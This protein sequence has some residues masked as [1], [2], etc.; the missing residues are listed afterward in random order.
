M[1]LNSVVWTFQDEGFH[2]GRRALFVRL[3]SYEKEYKTWS[4][5]NDE[6]FIEMISRETSKLAVITG[7]EPFECL[8]LERIISILKSSGFQ[9]SIETK[10]SEKIE[11]YYDWITC[12]PTKENDYKIDENLK[13]YINEYNYV[14]DQNFDLFLLDR[15]NDDDYKVSLY[16]S[17]DYNDFQKSFNIISNYIKDHKRWRFSL[18]V[19]KY[20]NSFNGKYST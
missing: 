4:A 7:G 1:L 20:I 18:S 11:N 17:P 9:I 15:H 12:S 13:K 10:G 5:W 14:V 2:A 3:P 19:Y 8:Q 16:L 6:K